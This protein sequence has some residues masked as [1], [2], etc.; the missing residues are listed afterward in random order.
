MHAAVRF[1]SGGVVGG[2]PGTHGS[3]VRVN[4]RG[5]AVA[6]AI[7]ATTIVPPSS[8]AMSSLAIRARMVFAPFR[9]FARRALQRAEIITGGLVALCAERRPAGVAN[10]PGEATREPSQPGA[11][12][13]DRRQHGA[14]LPRRD[15]GMCP[16]D[17]GEVPGDD[18]RGEAVPAGDE[19]AA[20]RPGDLDVE[21]GGA[22]FGGCVGV[23]PH[24][25]EVTARAHGHGE[26][27][28]ELAR[29]RPPLL[30]VHRRN[31]HH[32]PEGSPIDESQNISRY[33][34]LA[35]STS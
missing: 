15:A 31:E 30:V 16:D 22:P 23:A 8:V 1:T 21:P 3:T 20:A 18:R 33:S 7:G 25:L 28:G 12:R 6:G 13:G 34:L 2:W 4:G 5:A 35:R 9:R 24:V 19:R 32:P 14:R 11:L 27:A 26:H 29:D 10:R 17:A